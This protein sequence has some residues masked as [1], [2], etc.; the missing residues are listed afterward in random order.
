MYFLIFCEAVC[1]LCLVV[2]HTGAESARL[3]PPVYIFGSHYLMQNDV[4]L[5]HG[6]VV[7]VDMVK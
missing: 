3:S 1:F 2:C 4:S 5:H 7:A 6:I